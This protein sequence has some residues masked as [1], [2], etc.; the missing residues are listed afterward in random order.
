MKFIVGIL[1]LGFLISCDQNKQEKSQTSHSLKEVKPMFE[2][3]IIFENE[4]KDIET[5]ENLVEVTSLEYLRDNGETYVVKGLVDT[6]KENQEMTLKKLIFKKIVGNGNETNCTFY[7]KGTRK[8]VSINEE[9]YLKN[10]ELIKVITKSYYDDS[11]KVF[12]SKKRT[13]KAESTD[14][15]RYKKCDL[16]DHNENLALKIINQEGDFQTKFQGFTELD[17]R[18][19]FI[20][21]TEHYTSTILFSEYNQTL[22]IL[23]KNEKKYLGKKLIVDFSV[24]SDAYGFTFQVMKNVQIAK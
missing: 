24:E 15:C 19:F 7:Y 3:E 17:G 14:T 1:F 5:N 2:N 23:K 22:S 11:N 9:T 16:I 6:K 10:E 8:F 18:L 13:S 21:G 4:I 12:F 20:L